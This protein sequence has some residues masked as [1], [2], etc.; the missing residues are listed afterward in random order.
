MRKL[1]ARQWDNVT[2]TLTPSWFEYCSAVF[3]GHCCF[4]LSMFLLLFVCLNI[5][6]VFCLFKYLLRFHLQSPLHSLW[7][8]SAHKNRFVQQ[9]LLVQPVDSCSTLQTR[10]IWDP[11][12]SFSSWKRWMLSVSTIPEALLCVRL[13]VFERARALLKEKQQAKHSAFLMTFGLQHNL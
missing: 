10:H 2:S 8:A 13:C 1:H 9:F 3:A 7:P 4:A 6:S 11:V 12:T 5:Y